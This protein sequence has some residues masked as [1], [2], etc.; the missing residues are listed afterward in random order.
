MPSKSLSI[1]ALNAEA[2]DHSPPDCATA[3][4]NQSLVITRHIAVSSTHKGITPAFSTLL[5]L[6]GQ[7][8]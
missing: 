8:M 6:G 5:A 7:Q 1:A 4:T 3:C 2:H